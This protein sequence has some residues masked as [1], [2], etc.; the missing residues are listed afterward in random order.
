M[1]ETSSLRFKEYI[2]YIIKYLS[3]ILFVKD[4]Q[5]MR[6]HISKHSDQC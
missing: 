3:R 1:N 5:S 4:P 2:D 6:L